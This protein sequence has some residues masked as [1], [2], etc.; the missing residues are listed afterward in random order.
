MSNSMSKFFVVA[1]SMAAIFAVGA[2]AQEV[3]PSEEISK[4]WAA[5]QAARAERQERLDDL[6]VIMATEMAEIRASI[7]SAERESLMVAH[8]ENMNEAMSLMRSLGGAHMRTVMAEHLGSGM[9]P[10]MVANKS[11]QMHMKMD[12]DSDHPH[13]QMSHEERL[14]DL[15]IRMDMTHIMMESMM[16]IDSGN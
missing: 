1:V 10:G 9:K 13:H 16:E 14:K 2:W 5:E 15:E 4:Q 11:Q 6:M 12:M 3:D 8:R 7:N